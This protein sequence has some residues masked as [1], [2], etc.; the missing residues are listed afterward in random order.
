MPAS[1]LLHIYDVNRDVLVHRFN[2]LLCPLGL[3][4]FHAGVEVYDQ[5]YNFGYFGDGPGTGVYC[6]VPCTNPGFA[7]RES[8]EMGF[9]SM[10]LEQV[11]ALI[12][13]LKF[14]WPSTRYN[15]LRRNCCH[16]ADEICREL[17][18]GAIPSWVL[19]LVGGAALF[20]S[21]GR[22]VL[23]QN[24][25]AAEAQQA[26]AQ[27]FLEMALDLPGRC[28]EDSPLKNRHAT[29]QLR[30]PQWPPKTGYHEAFN[31]WHVCDHSEDWL[32]KPRQGI[33]FHSPTE[34]LWRQCQTDPEKFEA[35]ETRITCKAARR[36]A[37]NASVDDRA[38]LR[39]C[40]TMWNWQLKKF[41]DME[42]DLA[43]CEKESPML[44]KLRT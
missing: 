10:S 41:E 30:P 44:E 19:N 20:A 38:L 31:G 35:V 1:V 15:L 18:V 2:S 7:F 40:V 37:G 4:A 36:V 6:C 16:F 22:A 3:G 24:V 28:N 42:R 25:E 14:E 12:S 9:T 23:F 34:T 33:Y 32:Y 39:V 21:F 29:L 13:R 11:A 27:K 43:A 8:V 5:E 17:G 26:R